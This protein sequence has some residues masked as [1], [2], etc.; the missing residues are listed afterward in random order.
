M[1]VSPPRV[2]LRKLGYSP[3][4]NIYI[5]MRVG[6][7]NTNDTAAHAAELGAMD[8]SQPSLTLRVSFG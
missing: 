3:A 2:K 4:K 1:A 8:P 6:R 5:E 7:M